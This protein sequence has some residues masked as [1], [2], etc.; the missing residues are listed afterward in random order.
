MCVRAQFIPCGWTNALSGKHNSSIDTYRLAFLPAHG[1]YFLDLACRPLF[2]PWVNPQNKEYLQ[3]DQQAFRHSSFI[4]VM[5]YWL[6]WTS[7]LEVQMAPLAQSA[8]IMGWW[9]LRQVDSSD[10]DRTGKENDI[11]F[12]TQQEVLDLSLIAQGIFTSESLHILKFVR[13]VIKWERFLCRIAFFKK[14][15]SYKISIFHDYD[16]QDAS[17][18]MSALHLS[19]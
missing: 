18:Q 8:S 19:D 15:R 11:H 17:C 1:F 9:R 14:K 3:K 12:W 6:Y 16:N 2:I 10:L 5:P 4:F 7:R 13:D